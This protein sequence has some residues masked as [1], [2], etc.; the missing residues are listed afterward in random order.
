[1]E[2][3]QISG[4]AL[5]DEVLRGQVMKMRDEVD[6]GGVFATQ[7]GQ[8]PM[9]INM[10]VQSRRASGIPVMASHALYPDQ[11]VLG[12]GAVPDDV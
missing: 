11:E 5:R 9:T 4:S 7:R 1:M 8:S 6:G 2:A 12:K 3:E 10:S